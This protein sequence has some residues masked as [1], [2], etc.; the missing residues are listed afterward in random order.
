MLIDI[1]AAQSNSF[2][3]LSIFS[4]DFSPIMDKSRNGGDIVTVGLMNSIRN[5]FQDHE[6]TIV[7]N[8]ESQFKEL[9]NPFVKDQE[10]E[11]VLVWLFLSDVNDRDYRFSFEAQALLVKKFDVAQ[12][13]SIVLKQLKKK[14][15]D[16]Y[17]KTNAALVNKKNK[18]SIIPNSYLY[19]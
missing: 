4:T 18:F 8:I 7:A 5:S 15:F 1:H 11:D 9:F 13:R 6:A 3:Q 19:G 14:Y 10:R 16:L 2:A 17:E 12:M